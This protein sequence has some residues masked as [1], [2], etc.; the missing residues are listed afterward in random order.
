MFL[1]F[2]IMFVT[3]DKI[4]EACRR[5]QYVFPYTECFD[6]QL[7]PVNCKFSNSLSSSIG[8]VISRIIV[9]G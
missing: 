7:Y 6:V 2:V 3:L 1:M 9:I 8:E 4:N 5:I